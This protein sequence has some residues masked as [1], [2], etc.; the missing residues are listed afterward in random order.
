[1]RAGGGAGAVPLS[2]KGRRMGLTRRGA[3]GRIPPGDAL[4]CGR[5]FGS[6][7]RCGSGGLSG[8]TVMGRGNAGLLA[9]VLALAGCRAADKAKAPDKKEAPGSPASRPKAKDRDKDT[10]PGGG[11]TW[12]D[13]LGKLPGT[14]G[15]VPPA[16]SWAD[17]RD[18]NADISTEVRGL[19]GGVVLDAD[20]RR[21]PNA[22]IRIEAADAPASAA[23]LAP[24]TIVSDAKGYFLAHL[25]PNAAYTVSVQVT[26][27]GRTLA[28]T[29]QTRLPNPNLT[30]QLREDLQPLPPGAATPAAPAATP[31]DAG[32]SALPPPANER[33]FPPAPAASASRELPPASD[34]FPPPAGV[35]GR[36]ADGGG[37]APDKTG[38]PLNRLAPLAPVSPSP[39]SPAVRPENITADPSQ[40]FRAPP[41]SIPPPGVP[42]LPSGVPALPPLDPTK[43]RS[44]AVRPAANFVLVDTL[45]RPWSLDASRYG[46]L[47]LLDFMTTTCVPCKQTVPVLKDLQSRYGGAGG[48]QVVGVACDEAPLKER[49]RRA[50]SYAEKYDLNYALYVEPGADPGRVRERFKVEQ[51]PTL[52][53]LDAAGNVAWKGHPHSRADLEAVI[54][55]LLPAGR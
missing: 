55:R 4:N 45:E 2:L 28:A 46:S 51:Y 40:N 3:G 36:P 14:G 7:R 47:V 50:A 13:D 43:A 27:E 22:T 44:N 35:P 9:A 41:A 53:L 37:W 34:A 48:L 49:A 8:G 23:G 54:Q 52:V 18:P 6:W 39:A 15:A 11:P 5:L 25:R 16:G 30:I 33:D 10:P 12:L 38:T 31:S 1:M 20:G 24:I 26:A 19:L 17:P 29:R 32:T 42:A 21:V